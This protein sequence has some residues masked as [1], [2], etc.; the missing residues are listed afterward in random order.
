MKKVAFLFLIKDSIT[1]ELVWE[2]YFKNLDV[3]QYSIYIHHK[4]GATLGAFFYKYQISNCVATEWGHISL[5]RAQNLLLTRA[6]ED[7][8]NEHFVFVSGDAISTKPFHV[9]YNQLDTSFSYF[10][11]SP[12]QNGCFPRTNP[13]LR[14]IDK[15]HIQKAHQWCILN[16]KHATLM[17]TNTEYIDWFN[18]VP[19]TDEH[20]YITYIYVRGL[21]DEI[22]GND[23]SSDPTTNL[24]YANWTH[25]RPAQRLPR[26]YKTITP[27]EL[28]QLINGRCL[29]A[30][31]FAPQA[32]AS[33]ALHPEY[34]QKMFFVGTK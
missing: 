10:T 22:V 13:A 33:I 18:G 14:F 31:K 25:T 1:L 29:F 23:D 17:T 11:K 24:T 28:E 3:C 32:L 12:N 4:D 27:E 15:K 6:L 7:P 26:L 34:I 9:L 2:L 19:C 30:R 20:C 16:R 21:Q 5:V 8:D